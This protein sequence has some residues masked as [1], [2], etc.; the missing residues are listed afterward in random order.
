MREL[1]EKETRAIHGGLTPA[2]AIFDAA[3]ISLGMFYS[4]LEEIFV[5][6]PDGLNPDTPD[7]T[8]MTGKPRMSANSPAGFAG[9]VTADISIRQADGPEGMAR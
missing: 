4:G 6:R 9:R 7:H 8:P 1:S 5:G 2:N 3:A